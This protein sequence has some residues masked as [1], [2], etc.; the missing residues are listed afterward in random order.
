MLQTKKDDI[1]NVALLYGYPYW[2]ED[3]QWVTKETMMKKSG[4]SL[5]Y[6]YWTI[7]VSP[8]FRRLRY[9][10]RCRNGEKT[11]YYTERGFF[12]TAPKDQFSLYTPFRYVF[13][14]PIGI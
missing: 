5:L 1:H 3:G 6:D 11:I 2:W 7:T 13:S 14:T 9:G 10:F 8:E 4:T 12:D